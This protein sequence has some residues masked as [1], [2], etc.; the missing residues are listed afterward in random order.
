MTT[1]PTSGNRNDVGRGRHPGLADRP[2]CLER[3]L[4][5]LAG[6]VAGSAV[7]LRPHAKTHKCA[8]I[9]RRQMALGAV[10]VCCQKVGEAEAMVYGGVS[11]VLVSNPSGRGYQAEALGGAGSAGADLRVRR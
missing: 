3:N 9:A 11:N 10:G 8:V 2:G 7:R 6:A 5:H 4:K 1:R